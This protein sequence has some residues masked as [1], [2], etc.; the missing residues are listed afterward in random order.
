[1]SGTSGTHSLAIVVTYFPDTAALLKLLG[2]L[3]KETDFIVIDNGTPNIQELIESIQVYER[4]I[5][6]RQLKVGEQ[7]GH[8]V[9]RDVSEVALVQLELERV[10]LQHVRA[11]LREVRARADACT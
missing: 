7:L 10:D 3:N 8:V 2:Q 11:H 9:E 4:C 1:M 6:L 5:E